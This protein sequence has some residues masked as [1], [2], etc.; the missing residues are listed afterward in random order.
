MIDNFGTVFPA[1]D[2]L[3]FEQ[4]DHYFVIF[5]NPAYARAYQSR[6]HSLYRLTRKNTPRSIE[7]PLP[8]RPGVKIN[9][10]DGYT[11]L[12]DFTLCPP[13]QRIQLKYIYDV[14]SPGMRDLVDRGGYLRLPDGTNRAGR[15]VLFWIEGHQPTSRE[16]NNII[17]SDGR[18]R[19]MAWDLS[20]SKL[21]GSTSPTQA[22]EDLEFNDPHDITE[23]STPQ[24][25]SRKWVLTFSSES[26]A[27]RFIRAW[28]KTQL[29]PVRPDEPRVVQAEFLW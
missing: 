10:E 21:D 5:A 17:A 24:R 19:G 23:A 22:V 4:S 28:H 3:T 7:S 2:P 9:G 8:I 16:V 11:M 26:E 20:I 12:Q 6:V 15:A 13:S 14:L 1:R 29:A 25:G 18:D 27:R